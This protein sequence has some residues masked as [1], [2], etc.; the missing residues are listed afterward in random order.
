MAYMIPGVTS[1]RQP[2][3]IAIAAVGADPT[4]HAP[5]K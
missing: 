4:R 3:E 1:D 5:V 2:W